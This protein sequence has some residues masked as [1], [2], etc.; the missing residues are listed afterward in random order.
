[1][2]HHL[3]Q[4]N[5]ESLRC[6]FDINTQMEQTGFTRDEIE[7]GLK[8]AIDEFIENNSN[9][10]VREKFVNNNGLTVLERMS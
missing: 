5:G 7:K 8:H 9:W 1:M 10:R 4:Y 3:H 2:L 6:G